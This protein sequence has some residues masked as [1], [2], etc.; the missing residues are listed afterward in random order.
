MNRPNPRFEIVAGAGQ[1]SCV[2]SQTNGQ[3]AWAYTESEVG[4]H[5][6]TQVDSLH[7]QR[8]SFRI[9]SRRRRWL[10][11]PL[12][13]TPDATGT[14]LL[15]CTYVFKYI[16][17]VS[18]VLSCARLMHDS[19]NVDDTLERVAPLERF[20]K[21]EL[22]R[23]RVNGYCDAR[24]FSTTHG[25]LTCLNFPVCPSTYLFVLRCS[26]IVPIWLSTALSVSS[27]TE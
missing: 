11:F 14:Q 4:H 18:Q 3:W 24:R 21:F 22:Q 1:L 25:R 2:A 19:P 6:T 23:S 8:F 16:C 15:T 20:F 9:F 10:S 26:I 17:G 27:I 7:I 5:C 13:G 12:I